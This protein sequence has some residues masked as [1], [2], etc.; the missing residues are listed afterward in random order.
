MTTAADDHGHC[1]SSPDRDLDR[2]VG[3]WP[4]SPCDAL[5]PGRGA[6]APVARLVRQ[7][8]PL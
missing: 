8:R 7:H 2:V 4:G 5:R 3:V 1:G 6:P